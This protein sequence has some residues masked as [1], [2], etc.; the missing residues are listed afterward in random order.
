MV[1]RRAM[2]LG[3]VGMMVSPPE[4]K[5]GRITVEGH[6]AHKRRTGKVL[7]T[8]ING[9]DRTRD[10]MMVDDRGVGKAVLLKRDKDGHAYVGLDGRT[11]RELYKGPI[12]IVECD[13]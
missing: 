11:A 13:A 1:S 4:V 9:V 8:F 5:W 2:L 7:R 6:R 3:S 10:C 12:T